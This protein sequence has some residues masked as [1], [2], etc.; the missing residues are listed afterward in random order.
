MAQFNRDI[1]ERN[2]TYNY[3]TRTPEKFDAM[4]HAREDSTSLL[5]LISGRQEVLSQH[6]SYAY[7]SV[8]LLQ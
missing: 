7:F 3:A 4:H 1:F 5:G 8:L 6:L 2:R